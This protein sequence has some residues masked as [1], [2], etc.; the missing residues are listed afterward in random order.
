MKRYLFLLCFIFADLAAAPRD[1]RDV[2]PLF[3]E[4]NPDRELTVMGFLERSGNFKQMYAL[5]DELLLDTKLGKNNL[6]GA[7]NGKYTVFLPTDDAM[8]RFGKLGL[9]RTPEAVKKGLLAKFVHYHIVP[10]AVSRR[11]LKEGPKRYLS[12][13]SK[14]NLW[15]QNIPK[16]I[17]TVEVVNGII[18]VLDKV[19]INPELKDILHVSASGA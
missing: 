10:D 13:L 2:N 19:L 15:R 5:F 12:T 7:N 18:Y 9:L 17:Y 1:S 4:P 3:A 6:I 16:P 8:V 11:A 14:R